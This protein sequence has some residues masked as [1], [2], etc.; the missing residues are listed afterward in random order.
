M[1]IRGTIVPNA[2][3]VN[4]SERDV[5]RQFHE[6]LSGGYSLVP[7]GRAKNDPRGK[8]LPRY[9]PKFLIHLFGVD[10]YLSNLRSDNGFGF[11][12]AY[13][14][15][16]SG[17]NRRQTR[18]FFPRIFYK[19]ASLIWRSATHYIHSDNEH[20]VGKGD[21][22]PVM[23][24]GREVWYSAEETTNLPLEIQSAIDMA[25]RRNKKAIPDRQALSLVLRN[26][27]DDRVHPYHD[28]S[29]P[30][31]EAMADASMRV[32]RG[33]PVAWFE[34]PDEPASLRFATGFNPD[35]TSGIVDISHSRSHMYGGAIEKYRIVSVNR[36][37]QYM[38]VAA[39]EH[40]WIIPPQPLTTEITSYG[41][42]PSDVEVDENLCIPGFEYHYMDESVEPPELHS[43]IPAGY[44]GRPSELDSGRAD[45]SRWNER[46]PVVREFR[47]LVRPRA[48][49]AQSL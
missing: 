46:M 44:A 1:Q 17:R 28:F 26:A 29:Q 30:R 4:L 22:K 33:R 48:Q 37:I 10:Y 20:W 42:R 8:L 6:L 13:V 32:N 14:V 9:R 27:P 31:R 3:P 41:V 19:D 5:S 2:E 45:A 40:V 12:V 25:S 34:N 43:Q 15:L 49:G 39:P 47:R 23:E 24:D 16:P 11:F 38:F 21:L 35:F 36:Q 18:K 7:A